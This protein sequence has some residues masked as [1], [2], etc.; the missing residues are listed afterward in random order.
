MLRLT[1]SLTTIPHHC[2]H[3]SFLPRSLSPSLFPSTLS[4]S[5]APLSCL[6]L[7]IYSVLARAFRSSLFVPSARF[8][9]PYRCR[10]PLAPATPFSLACML[11]VPIS[12][13]L[14]L[15]SSVRL[16]RTSSHL[17]A[18]PLRR[19]ARAS[20]EPAEHRPILHL[21]LVN[22]PELANEL[23]AWCLILAH[24]HGRRYTASNASGEGT[25]VQSSAKISL[26]IV[27]CNPRDWFRRRLKSAKRLH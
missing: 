26:M 10:H 8:L 3:L 23:R 20:I 6:Y 21:N 22:L 25:R 27:R 13:F 17:R 15:V 1:T 12:I 5:P 9:P 7:S 16:S 14:S 2:D 24:E 19:L 11:L 18:T 4:R